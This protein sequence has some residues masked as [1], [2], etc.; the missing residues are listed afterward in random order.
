MPFIIFP[1]TYVCNKSLATSKFP[2]R[3]KYADVKP[4]LKSGNNSEVSNY[5]P[6]PVLTSFSKIFEK[7]VYR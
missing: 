1:L 4:L 6:I 3:L 5:R 7:I 2:T